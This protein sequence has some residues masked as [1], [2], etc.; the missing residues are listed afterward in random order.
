VVLAEPN[1]GSSGRRI[2]LTTFGSLGDLHPYIAVALGLRAR[3]HE[4]VLATSACYR[5]KVE[6]SGLGFR[7]LRPDAA[8]VFDPDVI[9]LERTNG[10]SGALGNRAAEPN[11]IFSFSERV[12]WHPVCKHRM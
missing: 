10:E 4:A 12:F 7:P 8:C 11:L 9:P 5:Q 1:T 2:V 6:A 3:G